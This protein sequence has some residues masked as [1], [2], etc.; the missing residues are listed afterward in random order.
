MF[1]LRCGGENLLA[2]G[3]TDRAVVRV[4]A[5]IAASLAIL[6][7]LFAT[8][9]SG[10]SAA[11][12]ARNRPLGGAAM[13]VAYVLAG[14]RLAAYNAAAGTRLWQFSPSHPS[15]MPSMAT[16]GGILY[17]SDGDLYAMRASDGKLLW[18][19]PIGGAALV[20]PLTVQGN[21]AYVES[22][23]T[24]Y[25]VRLG[26]GQ[27]AWRATVG[28]GLNAL[29]ADG[30]SVYV[31][32][33]VAGGFTALYASDGTMR[34]R[35][36]VAHQSAILRLFA[37]KGTLYV[38]TADGAYEAIDQDTGHI[39]WQA[40]GGDAG[41]MSPAESVPTTILIASLQQYMSIEPTLAA[42]GRMN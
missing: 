17:L 27:L 21:I 35:A 39:R 31:A 26:D 41:S 13:L 9:C 3:R 32:T 25:A 16:R 12:T 38:A 14:G 23:G 29:L 18:Q 28:A 40:M 1:R 4:R 36:L 8:A 30:A 7:M 37:S 22:S 15:S 19:T 10:E 6:L 34:L 11:K 33:G 5:L 24:V 20:S 42:C 2:G